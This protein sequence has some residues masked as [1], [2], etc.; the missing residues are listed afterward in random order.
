MDVLRLS[1]LA[2]VG[3]ICSTNGADLVSILSFTFLLS[4]RANVWNDM[5]VLRRAS[6][7]PFTY[8]APFDLSP[9]CLLC[10]TL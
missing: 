1:I 10:D 7:P 9:C 6:V 3:Q 5:Q 4:V 8:A 2:R